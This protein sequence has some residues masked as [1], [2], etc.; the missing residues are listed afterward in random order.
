MSCPFVV[1]PSTSSAKLFQASISVSGMT[2]SAC[3]GNI[4]KAFEA[5]PW[6]H[7]ID[8]SVLT[9]SAV[10]RFE[11]EEHTKELVN[12]IDSIGYQAAVEQVDEVISP[13]S[14]GLHGTSNLWKA[15]FAIGGMTCSACAGT[16]TNALNEHP[17]VKKV[18][19]SLIA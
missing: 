18:D 12:I 11:G 1:V 5:R 3:V 13:E 15:S 8:V 2:C 19:V 10:V 16:I 17:W 6:L 14:P 7:S 9:N 4:T